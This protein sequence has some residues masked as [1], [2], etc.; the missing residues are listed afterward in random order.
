LIHLGF[1]AYL[2]SYDDLLSTGRFT[3]HWPETEHGKQF[4]I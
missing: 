4:E 3:E 1:H 2:F